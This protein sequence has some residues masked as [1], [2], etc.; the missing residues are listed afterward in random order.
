MQIGKFDDKIQNILREKVNKISNGNHIDEKFNVR[1]NIDD[2][3]IFGKMI[4]HNGKIET[5]CF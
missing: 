3:K 5:R 1:N 2:S 4:F